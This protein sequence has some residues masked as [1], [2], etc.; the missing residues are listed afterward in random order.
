MLFILHRV[1]GGS[2]QQIKHTGGEKQKNLY[3]EIRINPPT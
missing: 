1:Q 2:F 3:V